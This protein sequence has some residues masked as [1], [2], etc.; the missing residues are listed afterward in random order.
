DQREPE[1]EAHRVPAAGPDR[2]P[3]PGV[4]GDADGGPRRDRE[5]DRSGCTARAQHV[6]AVTGG[7]GEPEDGAGLAGAVGGGAGGGPR[8][9]AEGRR[10][11][12]G[13]DRELA[14]AAEGSYGRG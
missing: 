12:A 8:V 9:P 2:E 13:R 4:L 14:V 6:R 10:V 3:V 5:Q 7:S 1:G 11:H